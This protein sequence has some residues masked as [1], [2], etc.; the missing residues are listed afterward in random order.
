MSS[1]RLEFER[2]GPDTVS[3]LE[4]Y[5]LLGTNP[6]A[7]EVFG[8]PQFC[9]TEEFVHGSPVCRLEGDNPETVVVALEFP[10]DEWPRIGETPGRPSP[11]IPLPCLAGQCPGVC[12]P[13]FQD[14]IHCWDGC[15]PGR[16]A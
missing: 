5:E 11:G 10:V 8:G 1:D 14:S 15:I 13:P 7:D 3:L 9:V 2:V 16:R 4:Y 12:V 6:H